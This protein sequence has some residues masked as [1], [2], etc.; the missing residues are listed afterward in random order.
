[1]QHLKTMGTPR[2]AGIRSGWQ[3]GVVCSLK[4]PAYRRSYASRTDRRDIET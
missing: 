3:G 4:T 2:R 1:M